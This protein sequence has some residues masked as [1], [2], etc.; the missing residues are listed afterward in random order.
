MAVSP[1]M[2]LLLLLLM[3]LLPLMLLLLLTWDL[4]SLADLLLLLLLLELIP[5]GRELLADLC[6]RFLLLMFNFEAL[7]IITVDE[8]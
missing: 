1:F 6:A 7:L 3:R 5:A 2:L 8:A 4:F